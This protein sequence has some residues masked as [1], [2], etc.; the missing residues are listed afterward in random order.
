MA[1]EWFE[2]ATKDHFWMK[3]RHAVLVRQLRSAGLK[4][5][6]ALEIGCGH[7]VAREMLERDL[8]IPIDGCDLNPKALEMANAGEGQLFVYNIFDRNQGMTGAYDLVLLLDVIEHIDSDLEFLQASLSHLKPG[9]IVAIHVPARISLYSSYDEIVGHKRR[10]GA[11]DMKSL[12]R[13]ARLKTIRMVEWGFLL[14]PLLFARKLIL[15]GVSKENII[16]TGFEPSGPFVTGVCESLRRLEMSLP[17]SFP[18]GTSLLALGQVGA[19]G[20]TG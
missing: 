4:P 14:L 11:A 18:L 3:W 15:P 20:T 2:L 8:G 7:G 12:F 16:R 6:N 17:F 1:D 10:Y 9:G 13:Q 19:E 5:R